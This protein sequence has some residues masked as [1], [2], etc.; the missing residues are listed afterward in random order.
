M[1]NF[2]TDK[3]YVLRDDKIY[4]IELSEINENEPTLYITSTK[5]SPLLFEFTFGYKKD[6][7]VDWKNAE[8]SYDE[9]YF[10]NDVCKNKL[11]EMLK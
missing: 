7:D 10:E 8:Y 6:S 11:L 9:K 2:K 4:E 3:H 5:T 1:E